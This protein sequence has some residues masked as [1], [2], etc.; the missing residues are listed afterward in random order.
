MM[1]I[2][3]DHVVRVPKLEYCFNM[4]INL[5]DHD[6]CISKPEG[7]GNNVNFMVDGRCDFCVFNLV[8]HEEFNCHLSNKI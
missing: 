4:M 8:D 5:V 2:L 6:V 1:A 7:I 3:M